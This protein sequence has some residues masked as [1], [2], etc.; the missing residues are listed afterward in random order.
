[1]KKVKCYGILV[2]LAGLSSTLSLGDVIIDNARFVEVTPNPPYLWS[3]VLLADTPQPSGLAAQVDELGGGSYEFG[4][5][6]LIGTHSLY[7][8]FVGAEFT[9]VQA[10]TWENE[11]YPS[12]IVNFW[13]GETKLFAFW[14]DLDGSVSGPDSSDDY[15]WVALT[16]TDVGLIIA[17]SATATGG[18]IIVDT[19]NQIPEPATVLLFGLGGLGAW[20]L[21]RNKQQQDESA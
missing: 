11:L 6:P 16:Y 20:L 3:A 4:L 10:Q 18:G 14:V 2:C 1:M 5:G 8:A 7:T 19:Y 17:D 15:G 9:T 21:R 13:E 12:S